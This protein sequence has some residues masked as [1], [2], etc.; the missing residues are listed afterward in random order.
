MDRLKATLMKD[1]GYKALDIDFNLLPL[2]QGNPA[3]R[4]LDRDRCDPQG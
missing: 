1:W 2:V 3:Q 4:Q